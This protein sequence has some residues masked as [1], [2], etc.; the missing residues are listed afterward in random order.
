LG[1]NGSL[2]E[3]LSHNKNISDSDLKN[4]TAKNSEAAETVYKQCFP[5]SSYY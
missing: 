1:L 2:L 5:I 4:L 3:A